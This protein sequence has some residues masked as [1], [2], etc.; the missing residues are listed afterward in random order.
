VLPYSSYDRALCALGLATAAAQAITEKT[1]VQKIDRMRF[2]AQLLADKQV[3]S[4]TP[5]PPAAK[6]K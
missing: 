6:K 1:S 4:G 2:R 3:L 5:P